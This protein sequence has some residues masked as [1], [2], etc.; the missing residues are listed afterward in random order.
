MLRLLALAALAVP[1]AAPAAQTMQTAA[2]PAAGTLRAG[3]SGAAVEV[4][5]NARPLVQSAVDG[6]PGYIDP[7]SPDAVVDW[8]G[9]DFEVHVR[10]PFD[11]TL[12]VYG[13]GGMWTCNDDAVGTSP[14]V[15]LADAAAGRYA[16]W[17]GSFGPDPEN[18]AATLIAGAPLPP[19]ALGDLAPASG[20]LDVVGGFEERRGAIEVSVEAGGPDA[21]SALD[22]SGAPGEGPTC[23]GYIDAGRP[24]AG[25]QY[26]SGGGGSALVISA[27]SYEVDLVMVTRTPDGAVLCNDDFEGMSP[28]VLVTDP[29][30][31]LYTVWVGTFG[32]VMDPVSATLVISETEPEAYDDEYD[33]EE[34]P[35]TASPYSEGTYAPLDLEAAPRERLTLGADG[36]AA[37]ARLTVQPTIRNP[38]QGDACTGVIEPGPSAGVALVGDGPVALSASADTDLVMVVQTPA[39]AW[40]CSDDADGFDPGVQIDAPEAGVYTVWVGT[41]GEGTEVEVE[42]TAARGELA[43]SGGEFGPAP[44]GAEPQSDATYEGTEITPGR[45]AVTGEISALELDAGA[46]LDLAVGAGGPVMNPVEGTACAG[47]VSERPSAEVAASGPVAFSATADADLTLVVRTPDG[48]WYCSDDADGTDPRVVVDGPISGAFS[49]W[50]GT[51]SRRTGSPDAR[52]IVSAPADR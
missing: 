25:V 32:A 51:F 24:T 40:F 42:L 48:A 27:V 52:L 5:V 31:G 39:G 28:M 33:F 2:A 13:P 21:A 9:G 30:D 35:H 45:G 8:A 3:A 20:V 7:A 47:F 12:L 50:V 34:E 49:V 26:T 41:F 44:V 37:T 29:T 6:C 38:V 15:R 46:S 23:A 11:A 19:P 16:V 18:P 43:V 22:L 4:A 14:V 17:I 10:A 36:E 1:L